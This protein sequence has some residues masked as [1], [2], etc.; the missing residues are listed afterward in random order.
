[1]DWADKSHLSPKYSPQQDK[2]TEIKRKIDNLHEKPHHQNMLEPNTK[3]IDLIIQKYR[4]N[5]NEELTFK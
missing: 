5:I 1:M 4:K 3:D 2:F